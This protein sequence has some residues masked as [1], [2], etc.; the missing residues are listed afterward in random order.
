MAKELQLNEGNLAQAHWQETLCAPLPQGTDL[1][2][3]WPR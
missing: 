2:V 3:T 1:A